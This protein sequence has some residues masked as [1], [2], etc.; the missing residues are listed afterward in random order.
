MTL[1]QVVKFER[2]EID[3]FL[4][5]IQ[6]NEILKENPTSFENSNYFTGD[7]QNCKSRKL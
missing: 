6:N 5:Q 2:D 4:T 7:E 1:L 3:H